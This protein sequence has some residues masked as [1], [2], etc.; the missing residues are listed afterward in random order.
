MKKLLSF[1]ISF[2]LSA[3]SIFSQEYKGAFAIISDI[4]GYTNIRNKSQQVID[5]VYDHE[6]L[7]INDFCVT[8]EN[9]MCVDY[10]WN[11]P[12]G[13]FMRFGWGEE[14]YKTDNEKNGIIHSSRIKY[15]IDLPQLEKEIVDKKT[16]IFE[17]QDIH[18][19]VSTGRFDVSEYENVTEDK[20]G[21][22]PIWGYD[23]FCKCD[24]NPTEIKSI[25]FTFADQKLVFPHEALIAYLRPNVDNMYVAKASENIYYLVMLN[26]DGAGGYELVYTIKDK[27]LVSSIAYR[28][29]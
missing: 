13:T 21:N 23:G 25:I 24:P 20:I 28:N 12:K 2:I 5:K 26:S 1:A 15:L 17:G 19:E 8:A 6:I 22:Y 10:G 29:F 3:T 9:Y 14:S 18:V 11:A 7:A 4:D 27:K 16:V